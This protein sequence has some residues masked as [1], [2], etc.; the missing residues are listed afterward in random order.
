MCFLGSL[1]SSHTSFC[2]MCTSEAQRGQG[3][4]LVTT[5]MGT[6]TTD[7]RLG[8]VSPLRAWVGCGAPW[9]RQ[10]GAP[11]LAQDGKGR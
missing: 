8:R 9:V 1:L 5:R 11:M 2:C 7:S 4:P 3:R 6:E 10:A